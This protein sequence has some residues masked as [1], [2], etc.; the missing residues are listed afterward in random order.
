[1]F[2]NRHVFLPKPQVLCIKLDFNTQESNQQRSNTPH[3]SPLLDVIVF[4]RFALAADT[5]ADTRQATILNNCKA[6]EDFFFFAQLPVN[7]SV[8]EKE[9]K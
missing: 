6:A 9:G 1:M 5:K 4:H 8:G 7:Y 2:F 3:Q